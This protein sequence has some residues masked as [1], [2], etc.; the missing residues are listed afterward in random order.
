MNYIYNKVKLIEFF[1]KDL[2]KRKYFENEVIKDSIKVLDEECITI[3]NNYEDVTSDSY[4]EKTNLKASKRGLF[5]PNE[6][7]TKGTLI[8]CLRC[9]E[10]SMFFDKLHKIK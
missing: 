5:I 4:I 6:I 8:R 7:F 3:D 9:D 2:D 1:E 10:V